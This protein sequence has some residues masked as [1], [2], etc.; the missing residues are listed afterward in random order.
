MGIIWVS[1]ADVELFF[2][3]GMLLGI[4]GFLDAG[5]LTRLS[6]L[7]FFFHK[8]LSAPNA[9]VILDPT[10]YDTLH[11]ISFPMLHSRI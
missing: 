7:N 9:E 8:I 4:V 3:K 10:S 2:G 6:N 5:F 11:G 1:T